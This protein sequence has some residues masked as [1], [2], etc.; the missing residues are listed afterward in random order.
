MRDRVC[1]ITGATSGIGRIAARELARMGARVLAVSRDRERGEATVSALKAELRAQAGKGSPGS[2]DLLVADLSSQ[3]AVRRLA[4][5]VLDRIPQL[6]VLINNAGA[7]FR[8]RRL[9]VDGIEATLALNHLAPFLLTNLLLD[10]L[11][12]GGRARIVNVA[13]D[14]H[15]VVRMDF[16]N[17]QGERGYNGVRAYSLSKLENIL[18]T[19]ELA[20]RLAGRAGSGV[21][22]NC[23]HPGAV[24]SGFWRDSAGLIKIFAT[25]GRPFML[26]PERAAGFVVHLAA[27][28]DVE[29]QS[30]KYFI[31]NK[32]GRSSAA[33]YD[34]AAA[35]RL[36]QVSSELAPLRLT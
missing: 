28:A 1:L 31:K 3:N 34:E 16:G 6:H 24:A 2:I 13:S 25:L 15:R 21:T 30:G 14:A 9:T 20:R 22:A 12:A 8:Q 36:W 26:S 18:F 11:K 32:E 5:E 23:L 4:Y 35:A 19:Y 33:S 29:G 7:I 17:L 27:G 10:L